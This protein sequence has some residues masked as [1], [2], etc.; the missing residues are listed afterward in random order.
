MHATRLLTVFCLLMR[1]AVLFGCGRVQGE[2]SEAADGLTQEEKEFLQ[3][4]KDPEE[5]I[6]RYLD[7]ANERLKNVVTSSNK[8]DHEGAAKAVV[9]YRTAVTGAEDGV[10]AMQGSGKNVRKPMSL[11]F[12]AVKKYNSILLQALEKAPED[13]RGYIQGAYEVSSRVQD[14][15][16]IQMEKLEKGQKR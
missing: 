3:K 2:G 9:G 10:A 15:L 13:S 14:G 5:K 6:K 4:A 1:L 8:G 12:R 11:L 16:S 7:I